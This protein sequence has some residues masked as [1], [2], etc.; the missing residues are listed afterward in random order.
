MIAMCA[1]MCGAEGWEDFAEFGKAKQDWFETF[2]ELPNGIPS[3]DT[4]RRVFVRLDPQ[5]FEA[6]FLHSR[7]SYQQGSE[8]AGGGRGR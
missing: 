8:W 7:A 1:V 6:C 2:L 4:F 5:E 3:P